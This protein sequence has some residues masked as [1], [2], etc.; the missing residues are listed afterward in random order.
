MSA[1]R[2]IP[3]GL[4]DASPDQNRETFDQAG[5]DRLSASVALAAR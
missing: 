5:L 4:I 1:L 2:A 3:I